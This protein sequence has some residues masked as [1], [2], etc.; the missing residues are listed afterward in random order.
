MLAAG[1]EDPHAS[2]QGRVGSKVGGC[3]GGGSMNLLSVLPRS[4]PGASLPGIEERLP[5]LFRA[6][7]KALCTL[8]PVF[9]P[10]RAGGGRRVS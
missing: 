5:C 6:T 9:P 3:T 8:F 7:Q 4:P 1:K 10:L 2:W